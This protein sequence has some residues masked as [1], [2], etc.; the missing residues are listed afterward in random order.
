[1]NVFGQFVEDILQ[2]RRD[3]ES[4]FFERVQDACQDTSGACSGVELGSKADF[5]GYDGGPEVPFGQ[6]VM[7]RNTAVLS[8]SG[9]DVFR[10]PGRDPEGCES[11]SAGRV[12][13]WRPGVG[14]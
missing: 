9:K 14:L 12:D 4:L 11:P 2:V 8:K 10:F 13:S 3:V 7:S 5:A 6:V 1:M